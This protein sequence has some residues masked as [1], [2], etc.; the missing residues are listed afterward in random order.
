M[1]Q[2]RK[3]ITLGQL[4][5]SEL[6]YSLSILNMAGCIYYVY[7][8]KRYTRVIPRLLSNLKYLATSLVFQ[9]RRYALL[10]S[11]CHTEFGVPCAC[12]L[13][14]PSFSILHSVMAALAAA[15]RNRFSRHNSVDNVD[16]LC[17]E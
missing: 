1:L 8:Y 2:Q 4:I 12:M 7:I 17:F 15:A 14:P 9:T 11:S 6:L 16:V 5:S 13:I 10:C 3:C